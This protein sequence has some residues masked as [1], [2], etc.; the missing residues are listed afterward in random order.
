MKQDPCNTYDNPQ[1]VAHCFQDMPNSDNITRRLKKLFI[2]MSKVADS[3]EGFTF[4]NLKNMR[5]RTGLDL[6]E[7][8]V[9]V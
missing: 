4:E 8:N 5:E 6:D 3:K 7:K 2:M 1:N 9:I